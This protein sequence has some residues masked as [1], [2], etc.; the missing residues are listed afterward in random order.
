LQ[1]YFPIGTHIY[2]ELLKVLIMRVTNSFSRRGGWIRITIFFTNIKYFLSLIL[3]P[4]SPLLAGMFCWRPFSYWTC[5]DIWL[6][7]SYPFTFFFF[8]SYSY[9]G[10]YIK[11]V[12]NYLNFHGRNRWVVY[13]L[14]LLS[15]FCAIIDPLLENS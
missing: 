5:T 8:L 11:K 4:F 10:L 12:F 15:P 7:Q 13:Y 3:C 1:T 6:H 9:L 14:G 2:N